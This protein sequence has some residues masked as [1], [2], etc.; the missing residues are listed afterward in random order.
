VRLQPADCI[1]TEEHGHVIDMELSSGFLP[2]F[3]GA[4]QVGVFR[5]F[6]QWGWM[7]KGNDLDM[8]GRLSLLAVVFKELTIN[9]LEAVHDLKLAEC[10]AQVEKTFENG[11]ALAGIGERL[12]ELKGGGQ[13]WGTASL[14][15]R[16]PVVRRENSVAVELGNR[17]ISGIIYRV[18][19]GG[20]AIIMAM[21]R[22]DCPGAVTFFH[23]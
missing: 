22:V 17:H 4:S 7:E 16:I 11:A 12:T 15:R 10:G 18:R 23:F 2:A 1:P 9:P 14:I 20:R 21:P 8:V 6:E 19:F 5:I 3:D 13:V